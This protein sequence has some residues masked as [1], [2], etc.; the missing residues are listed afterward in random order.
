MQAPVGG[1]RHACYLNPAPFSCG[2]CSLQVQYLVEPPPEGA[3]P[4]R[5]FK[6]PF[7]A[8]EIF[9][10]E[11]EGIFNTLLESQDLMA[12]L[13]SLLQVQRGGVRFGA[14]RGAT[15]AAAEAAIGRELFVVA[16]WEGAGP[17]ARGPGALQLH[18]WVF[19]VMQLFFHL[20]SLL[21]MSHYAPRPCP[22]PPP[23]AH[24]RQAPRPLNCMLAGYFSRVMGSLLLRRTQDVM[25]YL[26]GQ[27]GLLAALA[28]HVDTT[29]IAEVVVRLVGAD[30]QRAFLSTNHLQWLSGACV[31]GR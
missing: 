12:Q 13:F 16:M 30:E 6:Y 5:S 29:S 11:V 17:V 23:P 24:S 7:T 1:A 9:C 28:Y 3:D 18:H 25:E 8:C 15:G 14:A 2:G 31:E 27:Q 26:Q 20:C 10:C 19:L 4:K 21:T 22:L